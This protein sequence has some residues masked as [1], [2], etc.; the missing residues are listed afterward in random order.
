MSGAFRYLMKQA[1]RKMIMEEIYPCT[2]TF[3]VCIEYLDFSK[4]KDLYK[5]EHCYITDMRNNKYKTNKENYITF[6]D[7]K[8]VNQ[9]FN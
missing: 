8:K 9:K 6:Y 3:C 2:K 1:H 5:Y 7:Y 4:K